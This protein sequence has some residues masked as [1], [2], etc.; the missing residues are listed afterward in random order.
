MDLGDGNA[1]RRFEEECRVANQLTHPG[2]MR[3]HSIS[4]WKGVPYMVTE[5]GDL[6][7]LATWLLDHRN[8]LSIR[9]AVWLVMTL[10]EA[11]HCAHSNYTIH[12]DIKPANILLKSA[13]PNNSEGLGFS[14]VLSDFGLA[15]DLDRSESQGLTD[16]GELLGTVAYMSPE[17]IQGE[18]AQTYSDIFTLGVLLSELVFR[19][20][21]FADSNN[22]LTRRN[23]VLSNPKKKD[24]QDQRRIPKPLEEIIQIGRAH[25]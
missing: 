1:K 20:H 11:V 8:E 10:T 24:R 14:P 25:V 3:V 9:Q 15:K 23:I 13:E 18:K 6:G 5:L 7:T 21:P 17:Q 12:R 2:I 16:T 19:V 4:E 22:F